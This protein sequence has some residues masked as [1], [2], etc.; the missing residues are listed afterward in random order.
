MLSKT[1]SSKMFQI[2]FESFSSF[3]R[4]IFNKDEKNLLTEIFPISDINR[5]INFNLE[6]MFV[7]DLG[8]Q[9]RMKLAFHDNCCEKCGPSL[10]RI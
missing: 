1:Q 9:R 5:Y 10:L 7:C 3:L 4:F 6:I 8:L 2:E